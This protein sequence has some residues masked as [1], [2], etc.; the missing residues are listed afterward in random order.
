MVKPFEFGISGLHDALQAAGVTEAYGPAI[1]IFTLGA[2]PFVRGS[3][4][5]VQ[6]FEGWEVGLVLVGVAGCADGC[7]GGGGVERG[8][9]GASE[10]KASTHRRVPISR[11]TPCRREA[12]ALPPHEAAD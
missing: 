12:A 5:E 11:C 6:L 8:R 10:A 3:L 4:V 2:Q 7:A 9:V 1:I